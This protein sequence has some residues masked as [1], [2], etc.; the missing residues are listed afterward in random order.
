M[1][2]E[3]IRK[4]RETNLFSLPPEA[5]QNIFEFQEQFQEF[6]DRFSNEISESEIRK[7]IRFLEALSDIYQS[8]QDDNIG[9][10]VFES[11]YNLKILD[12][13]VLLNLLSNKFNAN[14]WENQKNWHAYVTRG[15]TGQTPRRVSKRKAGF[16]S[17]RRIK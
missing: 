1:K 4:A 9:T 8:D 10:Y 2:E 15:R 16:K 14:F 3:I 7:L 17:T 13:T 12:R 6:L 11:I 5:T